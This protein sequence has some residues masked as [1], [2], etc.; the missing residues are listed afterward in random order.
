MRL[1]DTGLRVSGGLVCF[2]ISC[3]VSRHCLVLSSV[4]CVRLLPREAGTDDKY[5]TQGL[6]TR[7]C[8]YSLCD[9][10]ALRQGTATPVLFMCVEP[11]TT[12]YCNSSVWVC[13]RGSGID[14]ALCILSCALLT[15]SIGARRV[16]MWLHRTCYTA[17]VFNKTFFLYNCILAFLGTHCA[18]RMHLI[19]AWEQQ[20]MT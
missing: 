12:R 18:L 17:N 8:P 15:Y 5:T 20:E 9:S 4:Q 19:L 13:V 1:F 16:V 10:G 3:Y 7:H 14:T 11:L 2:G 6:M